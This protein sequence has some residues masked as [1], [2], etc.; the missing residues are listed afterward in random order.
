MKASAML[1]TLILLVGTVV[2]MG[3]AS[4]H[5]RGDE[6]YPD[7]TDFRIDDEAQ[8]EDSL[9]AREVL[10]VLFQYRKA[11]VNK[12]FGT[13]RRLVSEDY[14]DNA[15]TTH[16]TDDDWTYSDLDEVFELMANY[17]DEIRYAVIVKDVVIDGQQ[18]HIDF[19]YRYTYRYRVADKEELD[20]GRDITRLELLQ[21]DG[22]WQI[23]SGL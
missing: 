23:L 13:L 2:L 18:A 5:I 19:E 1:R 4:E 17:A 14:Y 16:T 11:L 8:I 7:S 12:D 22:R 15:G 10:D 21:Q 9:E 6:L 3:C 20:A